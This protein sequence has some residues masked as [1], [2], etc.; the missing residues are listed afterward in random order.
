[1]YG[2]IMKVLNRMEW[3]PLPFLVGVP[4]DGVSSMVGHNFSTC[5]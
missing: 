3:D 5:L 4:I 1:M 2:T